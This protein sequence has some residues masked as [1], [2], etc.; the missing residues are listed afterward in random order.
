MSKRNPIAQDLRTPK[1]RPRI[2]KSK[3]IYNRKRKVKHEKASN[4]HIP[5]FVLPRR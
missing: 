3:R 4:E 2:V 5:M 1:Y